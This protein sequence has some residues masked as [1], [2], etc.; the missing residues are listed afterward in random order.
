MSV[1]SIRF[2]GLASG[3]DTDS[4]VENLLVGQKT[5]VDTAKQNKMLYELQKDK[6]KEIS[7]RV[8]TFM[9]NF[10]GKLRFN[11]GFSKITP[12]V[13]N[14][15]ISVSNATNT[16]NFEIKDVVTAKTAKLV[17][18]SIG[19]SADTKLSELGIQNTTGKETVLRVSDKLGTDGKAVTTDIKLTEDMKLSDL[20]KSLKTAL[21]NSNVTYDTE[22]KGFFVSSKSTGESQFI[23]IKAVDLETQADSSVVETANTSILNDLGFLQTSAKGSNA[24][25]TFDK[26]DITSESNTVTINGVTLDLKTDYTGTINVSTTQDKDAIFNTVKDFIT[27][28][29]KLVTD[30]NEM[31]SASPNKSYKPLLDDQ[32][33]EMSETEIKQWNDKIDKSLMSGNKTLEKLL[34]DMRTSMS[35]SFGGISLRDIGIES[36]SWKD[37]GILQI[38]E[39]KLKKMIDSNTDKVIELFSGDGKS[40]GIADKMYNDLSSRFKSIKG[41][42]TASS[43]FNDTTQNNKITDE[44]ERIDDLTDRMDE[45]EEMYYAKFTAMEKAMQQLNS[46]SS[47]LTSQLGQ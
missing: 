5:K 12:T 27:E 24:S 29:N 21:P 3:L 7:Q 20:A 2:S 19:K 14:S 11:S 34:S 44:A 37:K 42:K 9:L 31:V 28:Y 33:S 17:T 10:S 25:L 36:S 18:K 23:E 46:Q 40:D 41:I 26:M 47:W 45:M 6:Q 30:L 13:N 32:K 43:I 38:D 8:N 39:T 4:I 35:D 22:A 1:N 15:A 16:G